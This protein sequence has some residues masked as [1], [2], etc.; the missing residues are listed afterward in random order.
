MS[1]DSSFF[2]CCFS[3]LANCLE[4]LHGVKPAIS[5]DAGRTGADSRIEDSAS[6]AENALSEDAELSCSVQV[7]MLLFCDEAEHIMVASFGLDVN[8]EFNLGVE[9]GLYKFVDNEKA[10]A[11][12]CVLQLCS[13][14][15]LVFKGLQ[16]CGNNVDGVVLLDIWWFDDWWLQKG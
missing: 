11:R 7:E 10:M 13:V 16:E 6:A 15:F 5:A 12:L 8:W 9:A 4:S 14:F 2:S 1:E 3:L